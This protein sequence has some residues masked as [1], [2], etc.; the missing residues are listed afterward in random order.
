MLSRLST[1]VRRMIATQTQLSETAKSLAFGVKKASYAYPALE[2]TGHT[3]DLPT[4]KSDNIIA[5]EDQVLGYWWS[6]TKLWYRDRDPDDAVMELAY[7]I[8]ETAPGS[9]LLRAVT[10]VSNT[11]YSYPDRLTVTSW[12]IA[13]R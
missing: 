8:E 6:V 3:I 12:I 4:F 13:V 10:P 5:T 7:D 11:L 9:R 2:T 1:D